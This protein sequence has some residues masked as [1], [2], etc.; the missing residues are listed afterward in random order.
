M[1]R[2]MHGLVSSSRHQ[3]K[4]CGFVQ[5][6]KLLNVVKKTMC[7]CCCNGLFLVTL[8]LQKLTVYECVMLLKVV[9]KQCFYEAE[10]ICNLFHIICSVCLT[11]CG[12]HWPKLGTIGKPDMANIG[13]VPV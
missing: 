12:Q 9:R 2:F 10:I 4:E 7:S 5:H 3:R 1:L 13:R 11:L 8:F 6:V